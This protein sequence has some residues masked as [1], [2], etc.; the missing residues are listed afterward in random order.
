[1]RQGLSKPQH[2]L[3]AQLAVKDGGAYVST[4]T[5]A[6][7]I[8]GYDHDPVHTFRIWRRLRALRR[9]GLVECERQRGRTPVW[10]PTP[11]GWAYLKRSVDPDG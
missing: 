2:R 7:V 3:L 11:D 1:M 8:E 6:G 4:L 5:G 9:Y 10:K